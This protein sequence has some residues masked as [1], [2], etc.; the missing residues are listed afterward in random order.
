MQGE[1]ERQ[2]KKLNEN[3]Y[4]IS[5]IKRVTKK[6]LDVSHVVVVQNNRKEVQ[7]KCAA[8]ASLLFCLLHLLLSFT[9]LRRCLRRLALNYFIFFLNKL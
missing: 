9:V 5:S 1:N 3:T 6:F 8:R 7:K 4:E 2:S